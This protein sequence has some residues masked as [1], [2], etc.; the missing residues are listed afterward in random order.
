MLRIL[1]RDGYNRGDWRCVR[2]RFD[3]DKLHVT[4]RNGKVNITTFKLAELEGIELVQQGG[5]EES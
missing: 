3:G 5:E 4:T 1:F 2:V